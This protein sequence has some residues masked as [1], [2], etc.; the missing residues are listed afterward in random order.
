[1]R[2]IFLQN[3]AENTTKVV[4][5]WIDWGIKIIHGTGKQGQCCFMNNEIQDLGDMTDLLEPDA[6]KTLKSLKFRMF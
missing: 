6:E 4:S 3:T 2:A 5:R 1:M